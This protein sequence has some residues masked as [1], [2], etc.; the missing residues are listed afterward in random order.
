MDKKYW[1]CLG[2]ALLLI[3]T[4]VLYLLYAVFKF[5]A[6]YITAYG[7]FLVYIA[8]IV[9]FVRQVIRTLVFPG[10]SIFI[11]KMVEYQ[12]RR[13]MTRIIMNTVCNFRY[14]LED[15]SQN[16]KLNEDTVYELMESFSEIKKMIESIFANN[17]RQKQLGTLTSDQE[18]FQSKLEDLKQSISSIRFT[19]QGNNMLNISIWDSDQEFDEETLLGCRF[20]DNL[21]ASI[22]DLD[23]F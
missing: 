9:Y 3:G 18:V 15:T 12:V 11:R 5:M 2:I 1:I 17:K 23:G 10:S 6:W 8:C 21:K 19:K 22:S 20:S 13:Q 7:A 16:P 4:S 14:T